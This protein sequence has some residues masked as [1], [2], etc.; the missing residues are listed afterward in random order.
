MEV[1]TDSL[2]ICI[3]CIYICVRMYVFV[4]AAG[5][6]EVVPVADKT[7]M[8]AAGNTGVDTFL[9]VRLLSTPCVTAALTHDTTV[10]HMA[11]SVWAPVA[12]FAQ[13]SLSTTMSRHK[14][15]TSPLVHTLN[16][17]LQPV[18]SHT[19]SCCCARVFL[20]TA[21]DHKNGQKWS[22]WSKMPASLPIIPGC[23]PQMLIEFMQLLSIFRLTRIGVLWRSAAEAVLLAMSI[24]PISSYSWM[25]L[26]C[27]MRAGLS[28]RQYA[29]DSTLASTYIP[30]EH[31]YTHMSWVVS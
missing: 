5:A 11:L 16:C 7:G 6:L 17:M 22:K 1:G 19:H 23:C 26:E 12:N 27:V 14:L 4:F 13:A 3:M 15:A 29:F 20:T 28:P 18:G 24:T 9:M 30:G 31:L 21:L 2:H 10:I 8:D 25:S